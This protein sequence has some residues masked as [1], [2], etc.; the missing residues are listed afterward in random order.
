MNH[1]L[2]ARN[3]FVRVYNGIGNNCYQIY[4]NI[5]K[6]VAVHWISQQIE[7]LIIIFVVIVVVCGF[8]WFVIACYI[9]HVRNVPLSLLHIKKKESV[10][11]FL[12]MEWLIVW[13]WWWGW[14]YWW[15]TQTIKKSFKFK[16]YKTSA[17]SLFFDNFLCSIR[18]V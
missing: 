17:F 16:R 8:D 9:C 6:F 14:Q 2:L 4:W 13:W 15:S 10:I 12:Q 5:S 18:S 7:R 1:F 3:N 11:C